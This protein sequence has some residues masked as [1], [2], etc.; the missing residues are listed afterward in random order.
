MYVGK[1]KKEAFGFISDKIQG[2]L[3]AWCNKDLSKTGKLTPIKSSAQTTPNFWMSLFLIPDS[4]CDEIERKMNAFLWGRGSNG[5]GVKLITWKRLCV[6]K[7]FGGLGLKELK[8]FNMA[9]S[10]KQGWRLLT[11][12]NLLVITVMKAI[13][14]SEMNLLNAE[15]GHNPSYVSRGIFASLEAVRAIA[16]R[17]IG[18]EE[19]TMV[20]RVPWLPDEGNGYVSTSEYA[21]LASTKVSNLMMVNERKWEIELIDD[22]FDARDSAL[23]KCISLSM[24]V[25]IDSW[26]WLLEE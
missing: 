24:H 12:A 6:P 5:R 7:E 1:S 23:I 19:D 22:L 21:Q 13:Y 18:D 25:N 9:M 14:Y 11:E 3:Q 15:L 26:Y 17:K 10:A 20:W 4:I 16:W 8:K 2:K